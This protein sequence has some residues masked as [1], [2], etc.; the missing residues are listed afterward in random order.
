MMDFNEIV[1]YQL[2]K[3]YARI[4]AH[5]DEKDINIALI[6]FCEVVGVQ[7]V[8]LPN[9]RHALSETDTRRAI[10]RKILGEG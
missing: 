7:P 10:T 9:F 3:A 8:W 1:R 6:A 4:D 5:S 2:L